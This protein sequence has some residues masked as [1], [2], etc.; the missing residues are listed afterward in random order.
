MHA[1]SPQVTG[2]SPQSTAQFRH[3]SVLRHVR[4]PQTSGQPKQPDPVQP[5]QRLGGAPQA[6]QS[7]WQNSQVSTFWMHTPSPH[8][9]GEHWPQS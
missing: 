5:K 8:T 4:S 3:V 1:P 9:A 7:S 6:P 2:Q